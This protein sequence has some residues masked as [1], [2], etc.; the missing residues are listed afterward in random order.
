M[1]RFKHII[2][3]QQ[4]S[5]ES[6][7]EIFKQTEMME[8][9]LQEGHVP[10]Y[11]G[12]EGKILCSLFY[13]VSTRT[14]WS[15][16]VAMLR[17]GG[18]YIKT[19]NARQ[20]SSVAK[21]ET[22]EH[23]IQLVSGSGKFHCRYADVIVLRH[24]EIGAA[25]K[26]AEV[27]AVPIINAGDGP[28][29]HPTQALLDLYTI[30]KELGYVDGLS[31]AMV[32]DLINGRTVRSLSYLLSKYKNVKIYFVA[33]EALKMKQ[34]IKDHLKEH[35]VHFEEMLDLREVASRVDFIYVT[36]I[37]KNRF[38]DL[39]KL[40][41]HLLNNDFKLS[42]QMTEEL[43][44]SVAKLK[45]YWANKENYTITSEIMDLTKK[46]GTLIGHPMPIDKEELEIRP[47]VEGHPRVIFLRQAGNGVP[48]RMALLSMLDWD[49]F[50][51]EG[52]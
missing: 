12:L 13:E 35:K 31:I 11:A 30:Q 24:D 40:A 17:L 18:D 48:I 44:L 5:R 51:R 50:Q 1:T 9:F 49:F 27:S 34:D 41:T 25:K 4:F 52:K 47:E 45:D 2:E 42:P 8:E 14:R 16:E 6:I 10:D 38:L 22:L 28:G 20:F 36:R 26:A 15:F 19:E 33:P 29:Q 32:G 39:K 21:G 3:A 43:I 23:T 7:K 37:Q 46:R